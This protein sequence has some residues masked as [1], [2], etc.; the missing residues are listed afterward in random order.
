MV[1]KCWRHHEM[2]H[3]PHWAESVESDGTDVTQDV[4]YDV[5]GL[6]QIETALFQTAGSRSTPRMARISCNARVTRYA[7]GAFAMRDGM[8]SLLG[9]VRLLTLSVYAVA[10]L[11]KLNADFFG[12]SSCANLGNRLETWWSLPFEIPVAEPVDVPANALSVTETTRSTRRRCCSMPVSR[13]RSRTATA[14]GWSQ[15]V[16]RRGRS[17]KEL[18]ESSAT[19]VPQAHGLR[20][21]SAAV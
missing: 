21:R 2:G 19:G 4:H 9:T 13:R 5:P 15:R 3:R 11:H 18:R 7:C 16:D 17:G 14:A 1:L 6:L 20:S 8:R 10:A 12:P